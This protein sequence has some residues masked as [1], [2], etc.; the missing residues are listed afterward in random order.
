MKYSCGL[1][2]GKQ[3]FYEGLYALCQWAAHK[4]GLASKS[5]AK[6]NELLHGRPISYCVCLQEEAGTWVLSRS[7]TVVVNLWSSSAELGPG[8]CPWCSGWVQR[9]GLLRVY[10]GSPSGLGLALGLLDPTPPSFPFFALCCSISHTI[11][12]SI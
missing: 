4:P 9:A 1:D 8:C 7:D 10:P 12:S 11:K 3:G 6:S 5:L 2:G